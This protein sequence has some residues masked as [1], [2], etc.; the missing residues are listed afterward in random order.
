MD[1][2]LQA[3]REATEIVPDEAINGEAAFWVGVTLVD[4]DRVSEAIPF[5]KRAYA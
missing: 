1:K 2:A 3:Y 4:T 5:L